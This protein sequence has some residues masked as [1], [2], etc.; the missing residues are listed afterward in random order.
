VRCCVPLTNLSPALV[1]GTVLGTAI[2]MQLLINQT[3]KKMTEAPADLGLGILKNTTFAANTDW[4]ALEMRVLAQMETYGL[5]PGQVMG[6]YGRGNGKTAAY[7]QAVAAHMK[8][9]ELA[10]K[11]PVPF[12]AQARTLADYP[13]RDAESTYAI[14]DSLSYA[15]ALDKACDVTVHL[16]KPREEQRLIMHGRKSKKSTERPL[17]FYRPKGGV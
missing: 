2:K 8:L 5:Q 17:T 14:W 3:E 16:M 15:D 12:I 6:L 9:R 13:K 1:E 7:Q 10:K 4:S 11:L